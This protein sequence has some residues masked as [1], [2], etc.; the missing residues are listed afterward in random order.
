MFLKPADDVFKAENEVAMSKMSLGGE[1]RG[2]FGFIYESLG[3][4]ATKRTNK[5][6]LQVDLDAEDPRKTEM[7]V[8]SA[9]FNVSNYPSNSK[10]SL[11]S[12]NLI[13][14]LQNYIRITVVS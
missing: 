4:L 2:N 8:S 3:G 1:E 7:I 9:N 10:H 5:F 14:K 6:F 12:F 11:V 13:V